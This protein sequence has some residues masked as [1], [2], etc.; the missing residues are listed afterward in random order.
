MRRAETGFTLIELMVTVSVL[1]I[2]AMLAT[3]S[4]ATL[5]EKSRLKGVADDVVSLLATARLE[6]IKQHRNV[7]VAMGGASAT[8]PWCIGAN[9]AVTPAV[10]QPI[11]DAVACD[12]T[13]PS[14]CV[15]ETQLVGTTTTVTQASVVTPAADS[16]VTSS[17]TS[18]SITF[19]GQTGTVKDPTVAPAGT[20]PFRVTG[21]TFTS[22]RQRYALKITVSTL[23]QTYACVPSGSA[24]I[25]GYP[26]C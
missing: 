16:G 17:D 3:P 12:C 10:G 1:A 8:A 22:S 19:D 13:T 20:D 2:L 26:S 25:S 15:L 18:A 5:I 14:Q 9:Q 6:A 24:F 11:P 21:V 23:G 7:N 4:F